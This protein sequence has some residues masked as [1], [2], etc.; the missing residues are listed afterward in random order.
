MELVQVVSPVNVSIFP[1]Y[2]LPNLALLTTND[3]SGIK[4]HSPLVRA[5]YGSCLA[6]LAESAARFLDMAQALR[7]D[8]SLPTVDPETEFSAATNA[9]QSLFDVSR[10]DLVTHFEQ[11][12]TSLLADGNPAVR[13]AFL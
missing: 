11:Q 12:A 4:A 8:G 2:I 13:R 3:T 5:T 1:D 9:Y 10:N 6:S 7:V